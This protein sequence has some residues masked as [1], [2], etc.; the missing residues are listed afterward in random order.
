MHLIPFIN[1]FISKFL[2]DKHLIHFKA[3]ENKQKTYLEKIIHVL[4]LSIHIL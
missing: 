4:H 1:T 3:I 2:H